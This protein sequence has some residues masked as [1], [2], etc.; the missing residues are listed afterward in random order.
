M[1]Y[2]VWDMFCGWSAWSTRTHVLAEGESGAFYELAPGPW[3]E[4]HPYG[5]LDRR[6]YDPYHNFCL[7]MARNCL[8]HTR[9]EP[10]TRILVVE[11]AWNKKFNVPDGPLEQNPNA[12]EECPRYYHLRYAFDGNGLPLAQNAPWLNHQSALAMATNPRLREDSRR[13]RPFLA[14]GRSV[15]FNASQPRDSVFGDSSYLGN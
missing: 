11:E 5:Q 3:G 8:K 12:F 9:H 6:H 14:V 7:G 2:I 1:Y 10:I 15:D 13:G 4:F